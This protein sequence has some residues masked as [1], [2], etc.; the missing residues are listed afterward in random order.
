[1]LA[2]DLSAVG[3]KG[4][5]TS[6]NSKKGRPFLAHSGTCD[7]LCSNRFTRLCL[8]LGLCIFLL[9]PHSDEIESASSHISPGISWATLCILTQ[10]LQVKGPGAS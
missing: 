7:D 9:E 2:A 1:M 3:L 5:S 8:M 4:F 6:P 10:G